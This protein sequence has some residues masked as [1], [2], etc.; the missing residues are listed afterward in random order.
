ML[1]NTS[2]I[3]ANGWCIR[4]NKTLMNVTEEVTYIEKELTLMGCKN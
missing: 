4:K 1:R 3:K 2:I